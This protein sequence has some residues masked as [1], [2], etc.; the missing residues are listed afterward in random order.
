MT[1]TAA[2]LLPENI[3]ISYKK[4]NEWVIIIDGQN[5]TVI[6]SLKV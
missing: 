5:S 4:V 6:W 1:E 3:T 2:E